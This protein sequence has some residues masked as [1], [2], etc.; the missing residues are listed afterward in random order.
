[1]GKGGAG[2]GTSSKRARAS[3]RK[4]AEPGSPNDARSF[5]DFG[6][7][8][9]AMSSYQK[10]AFKKWE[11]SLTPEER[12]AI[13]VY[14]G[15]AYTTI[16]RDAQ[17]G[18]R[19][20]SKEKRDTYAALDRAIRKGSA[21]DN[22]VAYRGLS[23]NYDTN[24]EKML[25]KTLYGKGYAS[26]SLERDTA[27]GFSGSG[28]RKHSVIIR[29]LIPKG[30]KVA[31]VAGREYELVGGRNSG[32]KITGVSRDAAGKWLLDATYVGTSRKGR[33]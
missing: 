6:A 1:M 21:P 15:Y 3:R 20:L 24:P 7:D 4:E 10:A 32:F 28:N 19:D 27:R 9:E 16:N 14:K 11:S 5:R 31:S 26:M 2:A 18:M 17:A 13:D 12:A 29:A 22:I 23:L 30:S 25:G 8:T 33:K